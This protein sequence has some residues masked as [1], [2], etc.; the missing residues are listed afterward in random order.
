MK[1]LGIR[2]LPDPP[3]NNSKKKHN[4]IRWKTNSEQQSSSENN[5]YKEDKT[6]VDRGERKQQAIAA[7]QEREMRDK[8]FLLMLEAQP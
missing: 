1:Y 5:K 6:I 2:K 7:D 4:N 3:R 8:T